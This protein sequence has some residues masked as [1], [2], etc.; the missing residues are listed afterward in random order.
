MPANFNWQAEDDR[1]WDEFRDPREPQRPRRRVSIKIVLAAVA[2]L[3]VIS[4]GVLLVRQLRDYVSKTET[5][6]ETDILTSQ[7]LVLHAVNTADPEVLVSVLSGREEDW[8]S[9][10]ISLLDKDLFFDR[11]QFGLEWDRSVPPSD[12]DISISPDLREA[13]VQFSL[14]YTYDAGS[15]QTDHLGLQQTAI[16]RT[17][18]DRWLLAPP[19]EEFWGNRITAQG[20]FITIEFPDRDADLGRRL[21]ADLEAALG[22]ACNRLADVSCPES[23][24]Q[25]IILS[26]DPLVLIESADPASR[27]GKGGNLTLPTPTLMGIPS[28][29]DGYRALQRAYTA[30]AISRMLND[31]TIWECC[32]QAIFY[33]ALLDSQLAQLGVQPWPTSPE[34]YLEVLRV[35]PTFSR[36]AQI[37]DS[38]L[39]LEGLQDQ[40]DGWLVY[41]LVEFLSAGRIG[42]SGAEMQGFL[43]VSG[44]FYDWFDRIFQLDYT[45]EYIEGNWNDYILQRINTWQ[46]A[47]QKESPIPL[48]DQSV[49]M[50][51]DEGIVGSSNLYVYDPAADSWSLALNNREFVHIGAI[52]GG[53]GIF[54]SDQQFRPERIQTLIWRDEQEFIVDEG[55][56]IYRLTGRA[57]PHGQIVGLSGY[58]SQA[59]SGGQYVLDISGCESGF[60]THEQVPGALRWS[61]SGDRTLFVDASS[62]QSINVGDNTGKSP[63]LVGQ[64]RDPFWISE[65]IFGY[66][67]SLGAPEI[68]ST[69]IDSLN[70]DVIFQAADVADLITGTREIDIVIMRATIQPADPNTIIVTAGNRT[71]NQTYIVAYTWRSDE[72]TLVYESDVSASGLTSV[73]FSPNGRWLLI[74]SA[75]INTTSVLPLFDV[76]LYDLENGGMQELL[77]VDGTISP[78][79]AWSVDSKWLLHVSDG[80]LIL[81]APEEMYQR[82]VLHGLYACRGAAW[83]NS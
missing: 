13:E 67:Q 16:Y 20:R 2:V 65:N 59:F 32:D 18:N 77:P 1:G 83:T 37:W 78:A 50:I 69:T 72:A 12:V 45:T 14:A 23:Y 31:L 47:E 15:G 40:S 38:S 42:A 73:R 10:I 55:H 58:D 43:A 19:L 52:P 56:Q 26:P 5:S 33:Q 51:C 39:P 70:P 81:T 80:K 62:S 64:G 25:R 82:L 11:A 35:P 21:A 9:A 29:E 44:N 30:R 36:L 22:S 53:A 76:K 48:P 6:V 57:D 49:A 74:T 68:V 75:A 46:D 63:V 41:A 27:F 28:G 3:V 66:I 24:Q 54:L 79:L 7:E 61:P 60:C 71:G 8:T 34:D 17:S 4:G